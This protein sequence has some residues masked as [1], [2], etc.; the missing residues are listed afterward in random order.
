MKGGVLTG[1]LYLA[2]DSQ[3]LHRHLNT[4][5]VRFNTLAAKDLCPG[6][7]MLEKINT[8]PR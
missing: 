6:A 2:P 3:D 5:D 4:A 1:L 7:R 8:A